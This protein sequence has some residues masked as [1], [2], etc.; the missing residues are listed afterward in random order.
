MPAPAPSP[1]PA[2]RDSPPSPGRSP[3]PGTS[4]LPGP[5]G[6]CVDPTTCFLQ[7]DGRTEDGQ[8]GGQ[9]RGTV[10]CTT[11]TCSLYSTRQLP[12]CNT[13]RFPRQDPVTFS[14]M[15]AQMIRVISSPSISTTGLATLIRLSASGERRWGV[16]AA[17]PAPLA[18]APQLCTA[19]GPTGRC[20]TGTA[21]SQLSGLGCHRRSGQGAN[22]AEV[23]VRAR[24]PLGSRLVHGARSALGRGSGCKP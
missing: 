20:P 6:S 3:L 5:A 18:P 14:L 10:P 21:R 11:A 13:R 4:S 9:R 17:C 12:L 2:A 16:R 22:P 1:A 23:Q 24:A 8:T 7:A 19:G 15:K